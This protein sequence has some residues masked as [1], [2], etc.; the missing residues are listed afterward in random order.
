MLVSHHA[1]LSAAAALLL[2]PR[3]R[4][5]RDL[6]LFWGAAVGQDV[7]HYLW[8]AA[9]Y[10][11]PSLIDAYRF[12]RARY[13]QPWHKVS[14]EEGNPRPLHGPL[15]LALVVAASVVERRLWPIAAGMAF[16]GLLDGLR[17]VFVSRPRQKHAGARDYIEIRDSDSRLGADQHGFLS[18]QPGRN[19]G[20]GP[21]EE[22]ARQG[23]QRE[24][25]ALPSG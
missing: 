21:K 7:D 4:R 10:R 22:P 11:N 1:A 23:E 24:R 16:H 12:F 15:P 14:K 17:E 13:G 19:G 2:A 25:E 18:Q 20:G 8:F 9:R 6:V 3:V 5:K